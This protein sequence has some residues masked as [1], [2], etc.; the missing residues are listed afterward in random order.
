MDIW[1]SRVVQLI[2]SYGTIP[3]LK[4]YYSLSWIE[5]CFS[6]V[7]LGQPS[8]MCLKQSMNWMEIGCLSVFYTS[9]HI[10]KPYE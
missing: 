7:I 9:R 6:G 10:T 4:E 2:Q 3:K 8:A 5:E 1:P